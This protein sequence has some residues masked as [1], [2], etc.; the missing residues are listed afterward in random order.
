MD[1]LEKKVS[2]NTPGFFSYMFSLDEDNKNTLLNLGQ[3]SLL[4]V[5]PVIALNKLSHNIFPEAD[6]EKAFYLTFFEIV[7]QVFVVLAGIF[8]I[9]RFALYFSPFSKKDYEPINILNVIV[10]FLIIIFSFQTKV[11]EKVNILYEKT[12][13]YWNGSER[14]KEKQKPN[15][16]VSQPISNG[17]VPQGVPVLGNTPN[18]LPQQAST[19]N[20]MIQHN[21]VGNMNQSQEPMQ[22]IQQGMQLM[23]EPMAANEG[24]GPFSN[25]N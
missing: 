2:E 6:E 11:G 14:E 4:A 10:L 5:L 7:A 23:Q 3:Y 13:D 20:P 17:Q 21:N 9:N 8:F 16:K 1:N 15:V 24:F 22:N 18:L 12:M 25:F 19:N